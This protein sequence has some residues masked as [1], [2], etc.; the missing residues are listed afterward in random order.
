MSAH[1]QLHRNAQPAGQCAAALRVVWFCCF[2][3]IATPCVRLISLKPNAVC[4]LQ[5]KVPV[6]HCVSFYIVFDLRLA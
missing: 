3:C 1:K 4:F 2:A 6:I 5:M